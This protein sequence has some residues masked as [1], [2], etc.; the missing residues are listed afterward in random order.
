MHEDFNGQRL[1]VWQGLEE[2][3]IGLLLRWWVIRDRYEI[4]AGVK[5]ISD[6]ISGIISRDKS[7]P[8]L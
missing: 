5:R 1:S 2:K 4:V 7:S 3:E 8:S 6:E